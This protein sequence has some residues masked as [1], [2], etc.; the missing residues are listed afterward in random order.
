MAEGEGQ[1]LQVAFLELA[2]V[3]GVDDLVVGW[4]DA[5]ACRLL[6]HEEEA[7]HLRLDDSARVDPPILPFM[8]KEPFLVPEADHNAGQPHIQP[9]GLLQ[10]PT[11]V[12]LDEVD[13]VPGHGQHEDDELLGRELAPGHVPLH[14]LGGHCQHVLE[15]VPSGGDGQSVGGEQREGGVGPDS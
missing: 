1:F 3:V 7:V 12:L 15:L 2:V 6:A 11:E 4:G 13:L 14:A 5:A 10:P 9:H 8:G